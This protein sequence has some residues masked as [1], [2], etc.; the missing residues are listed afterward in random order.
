MGIDT[1]VDAEIFAHTFMK[2]R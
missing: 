2:K 1:A